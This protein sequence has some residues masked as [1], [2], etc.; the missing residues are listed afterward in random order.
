MDTDDL[1]RLALRERRPEIDD[2]AEDEAWATV[3]RRADDERRRRHRPLVV[4]VAAVVLVLAGAVALIRSSGDGDPAGPSDLAADPG[5][6]IPPGD[7]GTWRTL[8]PSP[9]G[10][11]YAS[12]AV[13]TGREMLVLGGTDQPCPDNARCIPTDG[14]ADGAAYD[15]AAD[16]WRPVADAPLPFTGA[17][18]VWTG[19]VALVFATGDGSDPALLAYDPEGDTWSTR[20][21]S[22]L[23]DPQPVWTGEVVVVLDPS[24]SD[25]A[26]DQGDWAYDPGEDRWSELSDDPGDCGEGRHGAWAGER[27]VVFSRPCPAPGTG[28]IE[29]GLYYRAATLDLGSGA[30]DQLPGSGIAGWGR[31]TEHDG[32]LVSLAIGAFGKTEVEGLADP[33]E[34]GGI[35]DVEAGTWAALPRPGPE[36]TSVR[37]DSGYHGSAGEWVVAGRRMFDPDTN[38][39]RPMPAPPAGT[40]EMAAA[41]WTGAEIV[42][43]GGAVEDGSY[44]ATGAAFTP[45][46]A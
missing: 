34:M 35:L 15:P 22:P 43:W 9:L 38:E 44:V 1:I 2:A 18:V 5:P 7:P 19:D 26:G 4:A 33:Q 45:P 41:V 11:R 6:T 16:T 31:W 8:A 46:A 28:G 37:G 21:E 10:A 40:G 20:A 36:V 24:H 27:L 23:P 14:L 32:R 12:S 13:W 30:W 39:W 25:T 3:S 42:L 29:P 17:S